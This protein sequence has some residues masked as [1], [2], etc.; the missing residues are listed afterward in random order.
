[1]NYEDRF[2]DRVVMKDDPI[3]DAQSYLARVADDIILQRLGLYEDLGFS[4]EELADILLDNNRLNA[5]QM[6][7][8]KL[9]KHR[10]LL[11]DKN[12]YYKFSM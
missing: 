9:A 6:E 8:I 12:H 10:A 1:M 2:T 7:R 5:D 3:D 4:P 11:F